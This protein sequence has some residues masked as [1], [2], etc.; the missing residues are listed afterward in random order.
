MKEAAGLK[1]LNAHNQKRDPKH[2]ERKDR[3][4]SE[5]LS[6]REIQKPTPNA[7]TRPNGED[8]ENSAGEQGRA[9]GY[10][11]HCLPPIAPSCAF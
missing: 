10:S 9:T 3:N 8:Q 4:R 5:D 11:D 1:G 7:T 6:A 2:H